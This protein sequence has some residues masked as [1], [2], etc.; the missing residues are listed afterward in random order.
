MLLLV[1]ST[2]RRSVEAYAFY[3]DTG[4]GKKPIFDHLS[5]VRVWVLVDCFSDV[6]PLD[7]GDVSAVEKTRH[8]CSKSRRAS[9]SKRSM[10]ARYSNTDI[11]RSLTS[12]YS[13]THNHFLWVGVWLYAN[14]TEVFGASPWSD[15]E[16]IFLFFL[17]RKL[18]EEIR[19]EWYGGII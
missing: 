1:L 2:Q 13:N 18:A 14:D 6:S 10:R 16:Y 15:S 9:R 11:Q 7:Q 17:S 3:S 5:W 8:R 19:L 12:R 4:I